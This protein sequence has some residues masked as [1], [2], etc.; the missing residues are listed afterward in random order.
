MK[1][2]YNA[3]HV[4]R[5]AEAA[6]SRATAMFGPSTELAQDRGDDAATAKY[7]LLQRIDKCVNAM[8][9]IQKFREGHGAAETVPTIH[10][11]GELLDAVLTDLE[12]GIL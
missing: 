6:Y 10:E 8:E 7:A 2:I 11:Y 3:I 5:D 9:L 1:A 4:M 12:K